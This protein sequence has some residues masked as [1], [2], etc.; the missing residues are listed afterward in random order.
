FMLIQPYVENS[1]WHGL[2]KKEGEKNIQIKFYRNYNYLICEITDN[3]IGR[4]KAA[5]LNLKKQH[6]SLGT[7]ITK[8]MFETLH[9]IKETDYSVEII[10]LYDE[11]HLPAGTKV[12]IRIELN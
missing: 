10:D 3:G 6:K 7:I 5:A 12:W 11:Q 1:I 8:E 9:K 4:E 2:I